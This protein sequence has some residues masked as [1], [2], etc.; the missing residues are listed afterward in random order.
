MEWTGSWLAG[1]LAGSGDKSCLLPSCFSGHRRGGVP[2]LGMEAG[3]LRL[4]IM[5]EEQER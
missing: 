1:W 4:K 3:M 2:P 5:V